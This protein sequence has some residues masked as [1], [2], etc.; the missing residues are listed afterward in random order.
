MPLIA[1]EGETKELVRR[2]KEEDADPVWRG[3]A[4]ILLRDL[5]QLPEVMTHCRDQLG[6]SLLYDVTAVDLSSD[7]A[8]LKLV[9]G[10]RNL[11]TKARLVV[12]ARVAKEATQVP[13]VSF[14]YPAADWHEREAAEMYGIT[15]VGHPDLRKLLLPD[16]WDGFPLRK[17]YEYPDEYH[18]VSCT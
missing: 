10:L 7:D 2:A 3:D 15:Y 6:Y 12:Q 16:D 17:D 14:I 13:S 11:K 8:D 18:G 4:F 5:A 9:Y 1:P